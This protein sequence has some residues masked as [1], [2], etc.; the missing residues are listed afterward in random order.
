VFEY[1][2][3]LAGGVII[4]FAAFPLRHSGS[5]TSKKPFAASLFTAGIF[6]VAWTDAAH[7]W[8]LLGQS[9]AAFFALCLANLLLFESWE[10]GRELKSG[11]IAMIVLCLCC[12]R[13]FWPVSVGAAA[14]AILSFGSGKISTETRC[15]LADAVLLSPLLF[16]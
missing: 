2:V 8:P 14:L 3:V 4:Y 16:S 5:P 11:A 13:W 7:P 12:L 6:L 9:A 10:H 15:A 1:G